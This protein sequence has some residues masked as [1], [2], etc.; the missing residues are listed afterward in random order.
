MA[1]KPMVS[2]TI[3]TTQVTALCLD[4]ATEE[5]FNKSYTLSGTF[6]DE[7]ALLKAVQK[8]DTDDIKAV[9]IVDHK[10]V[11]NLYGMS[12]T[13]FISLAHKLDKETRKPIAE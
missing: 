11:E 7:K 6:K 4:L 2:R 9:H 1:R 10:E 3:K 5:P 13:D 12:E 8:Q